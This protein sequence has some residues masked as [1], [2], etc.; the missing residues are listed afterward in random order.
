MGNYI[1]SEYE[2]A[3]RRIFGTQDGITMMAHLKK[4]KVDRSFMP[5]AVGDGV[6]TALV[7]AF[8]DGEANTIREIIRVIERDETK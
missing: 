8:K 6:G 7:M 4:H 2:L 5:Q 3:V 1:F